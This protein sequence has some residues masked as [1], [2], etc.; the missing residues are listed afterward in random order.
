MATTNLLAAAM[1]EIRA[2]DDSMIHNKTAFAFP[3]LNS[4]ADGTYHAGRMLNPKMKCM[5]SACL[6]SLFFLPVGESFSQPTSAGLH[7]SDTSGQETKQH[8]LRQYGSTTRLLDAALTS[9]NSINSLIRKESYRNRISSFNNPTSSDL[10]FSLDV[11]IQSAIRPLLSKTKNT[12]RDKFAQVISSVVNSP[13]KAGSLQPVLATTTVFNT[14]LSLVG[15]LAV[16]EKNVTK[17]DLDSFVSVTGKYF[18][19]YEQLNLANDHFDQNIERL[20]DKVQE[21]QFDIRE[22]MTDLIVILHRNV[23]RSSLKEMTLEELLLKYLD[24][25][26]IESTIVNGGEPDGNGLYFPAD[27]IKGA[28]EITHGL[29]KLFNDYHKTYGENYH[30]IKNILLQTKALGKNVNLKQVDQ[31]VTELELLYTESKQAD[32]LNLRLNTLFERLKS[33]TQSEARPM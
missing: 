9:L 12:N 20:S 30:E 11:E 17:E 5:K 25:L 23:S 28:K 10:G 24:I 21:L 26:V 32:I 18:R 4:G 15:N 2:A 19:Q 22:Y 1:K 33:L 8:L 6:L 16:R 3:G 13:G 14:L 29:Q 7:W 27:A 31:S